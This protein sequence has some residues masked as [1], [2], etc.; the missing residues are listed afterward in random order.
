MR[1]SAVYMAGFALY[2]AIYWATAERLVFE[3]WRN[4][5][6]NGPVRIGWALLFGMA[7]LHGWFGM[8]SIF[9]DYVKPVTLRVVVSSL[10]GLGLFALALWAASILLR[11]WS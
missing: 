11:G 8:R 9:M 7:L 5:F 3:T 6:S 1:L 10:T 4:W 2:V